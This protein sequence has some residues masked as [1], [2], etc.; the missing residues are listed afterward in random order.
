MTPEQLCE[1]IRYLSVNIGARQATSAQE[2]AAADYVD[3]YLQGVGLSPQTQSYASINSFSK[4]LLTQSLMSAAVLAAGMEADGQLKR[5]L[6][7]LGIGLARH[8]VRLWH[9]RPALWENL[10]PRG[11]SQN[12]IARIAP[13][14]EIRQKIVLVAHLDTSQNRIS[15][16]PQLVK[17]LPAFLAWMGIP[18]LLGGLVTLFLPDSR[19]ARFVKQSMTAHLVLGGLV[20]LL[21][22]IGEPV[23]GANGNASGVA[24]V[25][26]L[27]EHFTRQRLDQTELWCVFSGGAQAG[28]TGIEHFLHT[29]AAELWDATFLVLQ[30]VGKG[31]IAWVTDHTLNPLVHYHPDADTA[32]HAEAVAQQHPEWGIM[33]RS[34][35]TLDELA[36]VRQYNFKGLAISG[37]DRLT[38]LPAHRQRETD[39]FD[40]IEI[41]SVV[42]A[43]EFTQALIQQIDTP[44]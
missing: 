1:I 3:L 14:N 2:R 40:Q 29:H 35:L 34:M 30:N 23:Q 21:D 36:N 22:E 19:W 28:S 31:E 15:A 39:T 13:Q 18:V 6:G 41:E 5:F 42:K 20:A 24:V 26:T 33:G 16:H 37:Y 10:L 11:E 12:V 43:A 9:T 4:R 44:Q 17:H 38:G 25:L 8:D 7:L 27:A 32:R